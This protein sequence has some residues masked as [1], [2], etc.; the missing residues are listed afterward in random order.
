MALGLLTGCLPVDVPVHVHNE[1]ASA[2][3]VRIAGGNPPWATIAPSEAVGVG[4]FQYTGWG[5][6]PDRWVPDD[7]TGLEV[8]LS[9]EARADVDAD[10]FLGAATYDRGWTYRLTAD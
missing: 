7:F 8:L 2:V 6:V 10:A 9:T 4:A 3:K 5:N 1:M